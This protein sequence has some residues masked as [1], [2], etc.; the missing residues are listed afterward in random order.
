MKQVC[1]P[2]ID[3]DEWTGV[4]ATDD[5]GAAF[6]YLSVKGYDEHECA[7]APFTL[8][9]RNDADDKPRKVKV[10]VV[11]AHFEVDGRGPW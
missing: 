6:E 9:V 7:G 5:R 1:D 2:N 11:P 10:C 4:D 3:P 8:I